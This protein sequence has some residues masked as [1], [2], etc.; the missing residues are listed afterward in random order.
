MG[1]LEDNIKKQPNVKI[2][3]NTEISFLTAMARKQNFFRVKNVYIKHISSN[4]WCYAFTGLLLL[5]WWWRRRKIDRNF[6]SF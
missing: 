1:Q 2:D 4:S 5:R 6:H 3:V